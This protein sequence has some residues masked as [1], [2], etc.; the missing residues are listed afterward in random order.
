MDTTRREFVTAA[1]GATAF[2]ATLGFTRLTGAEDTSGTITQRASFSIKEGRE[3]EAK[4]ALAALCKGVEENEPGV[5][6]YIAH[7]GEGDEANTVTFFEV[8]KDSD[9][10]TAHGNTP[11]MNALR[12]SFMENFAPPLK[13]TKLNRVAGFSR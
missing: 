8:Y 9:A 1:A 13:I 6:A 3:A 11:H 5:L 2:A 4:E 12:A 7:H 10:L